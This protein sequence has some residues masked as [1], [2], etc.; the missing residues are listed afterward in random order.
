MS[1]DLSNLNFIHCSVAAEKCLQ[2]NQSKIKIA[3]CYKKDVS[4]EKE[5]KVIEWQEPN[6]GNC[7]KVEQRSE[8]KLK[9]LAKTIWQKEIWEKLKR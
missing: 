9:T 5:D 6:V 8:N 1:C 4:K 7:E 2:K 3:K